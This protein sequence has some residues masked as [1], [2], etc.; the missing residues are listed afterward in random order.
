MRGH[1]HLTRYH[2]TG[3]W[4]FNELT[5]CEHI[6]LL[7]GCIANSETV[8]PISPCDCLRILIKYFVT[9]TFQIRLH[10]IYCTI[11]LY[12]HVVSTN[13]LL[14]VVTPKVLML[15]DSS[16]DLKCHRISEVQTSSILSFNS[17]VSWWYTANSGDQEKEIAVWN[18][19]LNNAT[20]VNNTG[21]DVSRSLCCVLYLVHADR[22]VTVITYI[23]HYIA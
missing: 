20:I 1:T 10:C 13:C 21:I 16:V 9:M 8:E 17:S 22:S 19:D 11:I 5:L 2:T 15:R 6:I 12:L 7:H 3:T 23:L 14:Q 4:L 18:T